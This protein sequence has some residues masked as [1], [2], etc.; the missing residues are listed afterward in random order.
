MLSSGW[1]H[2]LFIFCLYSVTA[3]WEVVVGSQSR[4]Q[5]LWWEDCYVWVFGSYEYEIKQAN[6]I[7]MICA[8]WKRD[9]QQM[10]KNILKQFYLKKMTDI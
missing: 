9:F 8:K 5:W 6:S 10:V 7:L 1:A 2:W 3:T 4:K